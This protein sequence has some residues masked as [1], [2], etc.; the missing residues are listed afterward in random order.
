VAAV[1]AV[2]RGS[3]GRKGLTAPA[4]L[5]WTLLALVGLAVA[6]AISIAASHLV[7]QRIGLASEPLSAGKELAPPPREG[8]NHGHQRPSDS[9]G[10]SPE[11]TTTMT[12]TTTAP[13]TVTTSP[14]AS[15]APAP[16]APTAPASPSDGSGEH[17]SGDD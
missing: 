16:S 7:S 10:P 3:L 14:P 12:T 9:Q 4:W 1:G 8:S 15:T 2:E 6:A 5:R 11:T 17:Q 13:P